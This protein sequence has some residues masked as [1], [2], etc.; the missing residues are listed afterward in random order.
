MMQKLEKRIKGWVCVYD[1]WSGE[2]LKTLDS[3]QVEFKNLPDDG[4]QGFMKFFID[5]TKQIITGYDYYFYVK[6]PN[7]DYLI[8]ANNHC[9]EDNKRRYPG[10]IIKRGKHTTDEWASITVDILNG[11]KLNGS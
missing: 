8:S 5:G 6:H 9:I 3:S 11:Y 2:F 4:I 1:D 10:I 7:G